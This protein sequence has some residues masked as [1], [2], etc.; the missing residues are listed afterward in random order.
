MLIRAGDSVLLVIDMQERLV[1]A[2]QSPARALGNARLLLTAAGVC[3]VPCLLTEQ[4]PTGLGPTVAEISSAAVD[5]PIIEKL[6]FSCM[7]EPDFQTAFIQLDRRQAIIAG[8]EA[9]VCVLQ[10]AASLIEAGFEVFV[11][12]D[13]TASRTS[14]SELA[15]L[16]RLTASGAHVV[17]TEMVIFEWLGKAGTPAFKTLLP[18]I[19]Q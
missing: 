6:H 4:Y 13:A 9:H 10:T 15:C 11:V 7:E 19:K 18:L 8:M 3:Q 1:P 12:A 14:E 5:S 17:T 2:M 16:S